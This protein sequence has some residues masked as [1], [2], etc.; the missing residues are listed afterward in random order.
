MT[1][2]PALGEPRTVTELPGYTRGL[3]IHG[4]HAFIGLSK[5]RG[6]SVLEGLPIASSSGSLKCG[7]AIVE[8]SS[9]EVKGL[10]EFEAGIE[11]IFD[12]RVNP[13]SRSPFFSGPDTRE[14]GTPPI[15]LIPPPRFDLTA[16]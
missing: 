2:D 5:M 16:S 6:T 3:S 1:V 12:V 7:V 13:Y 15:W 10:L 14:D 8:L 4:S 11:E 9:G